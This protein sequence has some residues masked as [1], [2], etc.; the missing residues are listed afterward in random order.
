MRGMFLNKTREEKKEKKKNFSPTDVN[1]SG[2]IS[3]RSETQSP[4]GAAPGEPNEKQ[5]RD[6]AMELSTQHFLSGR[7]RRRLRSPSW[8]ATQA[9]RTGRWKHRWSLVEITYTATHTH[10][11]ADAY[12]DTHVDTYTNTHAQTH[13]QTHSQTDRHTRSDTY[14]DTH[15]HSLS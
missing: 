10:S 2:T 1:H 7:E 4:E 14:A 6:E 12:S 3:S 8:P 11:H 9:R 15:T 13:T 5:Q